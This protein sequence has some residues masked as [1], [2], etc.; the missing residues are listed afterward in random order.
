ME[1]IIIIFFTHH[2][3]ISSHF[4]VFLLHL[5]S[6]QQPTISQLI[7]QLE[8]NRH[9]QAAKSGLATPPR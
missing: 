7:E 5:W 4:N 3:F 1:T 6:K 8:P 2:H 9:L